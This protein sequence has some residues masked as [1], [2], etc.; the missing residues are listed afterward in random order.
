MIG[1]V[2]D[3]SRVT[4]KS[5]FIITLNTLTRFVLGAVGGYK[6]QTKV[7]GVREMIDGSIPTSKHID[8]VRSDLLMF[9]G[10]W[11]EHQGESYSEDRN[12]FHAINC[13]LMKERMLFIKQQRS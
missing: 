2:K 4:E 3:S 1:S 12:G 10:A 11:I 7:R 13:N 9:F 5:D 6:L 8:E